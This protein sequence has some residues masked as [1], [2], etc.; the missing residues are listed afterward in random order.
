LAREIIERTQHTGVEK[1][2]QD[3]NKTEESNLSDFISA[4]FDPETAKTAFTLD[5]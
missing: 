5:P 1:I 3:L 4:P 2:T